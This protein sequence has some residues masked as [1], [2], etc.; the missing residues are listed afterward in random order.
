VV[1]KGWAAGGAAA[2]GALAEADA[3]AVAEAL[4]ANIAANVAPEAAPVGVL[5]GVGGVSTGCAAAGIG[6]SPETARS[7]ATA[8]PR[9]KTYTLRGARRARTGRAG[10]T[11]LELVGREV[12][13]PGYATGASPEVSQG[14]FTEPKHSIAEG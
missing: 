3:L 2:T 13:E 9:C 6:E 14:L 5:N 11:S 1:A 12:L 8:H 4:P 7:I 10:C